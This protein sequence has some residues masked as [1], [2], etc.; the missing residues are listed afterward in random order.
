MHHK[1]QGRR[2]SKQKTQLKHAVRRIALRLDTD[3]PRQAQDA[4]VADIQK[5]RAKF[6]LKQSNRITHWEVCYN[7][8]T[9]I[10]VYDRKRKILA[11]VLYPSGYSMW[12]Q[13]KEYA[14]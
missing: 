10:A 13:L 6:I 14:T 1:K 2:K 9:V 11:T 3:T 5:G 12:D 4:I 7:G 8:K